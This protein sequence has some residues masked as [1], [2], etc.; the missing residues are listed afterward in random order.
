MNKKK[1]RVKQTALKQEKI[2]SVRGERCIYCGNPL[3]EGKNSYAALV[4][5]RRFHTCSA[6]C[7]E[8]A[9]RYVQQ[10]R[11][12][13]TWLYLILFVGAVGIMI[14]ALG[15]AGGATRFL[16]YGSILLAGLGFLLFPYPI[17]SFETFL[18]CPI[19][20]VTAISRGVGILLCVL[21][22]LFFF[23]AR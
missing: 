7:Q 18:S 2:E 16:M 1:K 12:K 11:K 10:D 13:K 4:R 5:T 3:I 6:L 19:R 14:S 9:E 17:T 23:L 20:K 8:A 21:A 22:I 15:I